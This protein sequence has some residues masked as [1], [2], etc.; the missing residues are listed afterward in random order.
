LAA[1]SRCLQQQEFDQFNYLRGVKDSHFM[2]RELSTTLL[3]TVRKS[4]DAGTNRE[5]AERAD[6]SAVFYGSEHWNTYHAERV[7]AA[8]ERASMGAG[9]NP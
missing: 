8:A 4:R 9:K 5:P 1:A 6:L 7:A 2:F 3:D